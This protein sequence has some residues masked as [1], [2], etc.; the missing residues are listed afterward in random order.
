MQKYAY[1]CI[2]INVANATE[3]KSIN[4]EFKIISVYTLLG[5]LGVGHL[6]LGYSQLSKRSSM[7]TG[8]KNII[9]VFGFAKVELTP[10]DS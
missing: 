5:L 7:I 3:S 10:K 9:V 8:L 1:V 2:H 6:V 4:C